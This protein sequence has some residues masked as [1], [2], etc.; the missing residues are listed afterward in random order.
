MCVSVG[1]CVRGCVSLSPLTAFACRVSASLPSWPSRRAS[2]SRGGRKSLPPQTA[3]DLSARAVPGPPRGR[4]A[5]S[6]GAGGGAER[7]AGRPGALAATA[8]LPA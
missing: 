1:V 2:K 8:V 4:E 3:R 7:P 5:A 6:P